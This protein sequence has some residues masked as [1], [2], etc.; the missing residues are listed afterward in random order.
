MW[1]DGLNR[2]KYFYILELDKQWECLRWD[3]KVVEK[4]KKWKE[5]GMKS[6]KVKL[7]TE[8][9]LGRVTNFR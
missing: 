3:E 6:C 9:E 5:Y 1:W 2:K 4:K 8:I 7:F